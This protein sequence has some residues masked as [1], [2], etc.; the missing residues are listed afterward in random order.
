[1]HEDQAKAWEAA[2]ARAS[3]DATAWEAAAAR[4]SSDATAWEAA[5]AR[6]SSD[7]TA[8]EAA[9][10]RASS[11]ASEALN[12]REQLRCS[13]QELRANTA[14]LITENDHFK[15]LISKHERDSQR[16]RWLLKHLGDK[17]RHFPR[18]LSRRIRASQKK[19]LQSARGIPGSQLGSAT[20]VGA[21]PSPLVLTLSERLEG[22]GLETSETA[23]GPD[24][25]GAGIGWTNRTG[26]PN[27]GGDAITAPPGPPFS[28]M[29]FCVFC[30]T[31]IEAWKPYRE[32]ASGRPQ[33]MVRLGA[34]GSNVKRFACPNCGCSDRERH[35]HL[36]FDRLGIW[37]ALRGAS[38]LHVAP[39][40]KL[41]QAILAGEPSNYIPGDLLPAD[42]SI[43]KIDIEATSFASESFDFVICNHVLEHVSAPMAALREV[44][45]ILRPGGR[46]VCQ[47]P[48][49]SR[50]T[51]TFEEPLLTSAIDR[52]FFYGQEDHVRL[53]GTRHRA[54]HRQR[55]IRWPACAARR[56]VA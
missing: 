40:W 37:P 11:D 45:R 7:A 6:A 5:A 20:A 22:P 53:F 47:T 26:S 48:Y 9:A 52:F 29:R 44:R 41:A 42:P 46:F 18:D 12:A 34:V 4:A 31:N 55:R 24:G 10:A 15:A 51:H 28:G 25:G 56:V 27:S 33:V 21:I 1:M 16:T 35:L 14:E 19:R 36:Y 23:L 50:L 13:V 32:G 17:V 30:C 2:A 39:E 49:A 8:W 54:S 38:V 3:S 43:Q